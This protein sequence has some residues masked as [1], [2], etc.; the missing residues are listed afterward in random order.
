[1]KHLIIIA[2]L[3]VAA[4]SAEPTPVD[5]G[6]LEDALAKLEQA[7]ADLAKAK[8]DSAQAGLGA[9]SKAMTTIAE[10]DEMADPPSLCWQDYCPCEKTVTAL[11]V[12]ICRNA[13]A[14]VAMSDDQGS[15]GAG[16]QDMKREGDRLNAEMDGVMSDDRAQREQLKAVA[17]RYDY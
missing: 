2:S 5:D 12:T 15:I 10:V 8:D 3:L 1:M 9:A 13:R 17:E 6:K 16:A 7:Q 4:C 11:D 14:G